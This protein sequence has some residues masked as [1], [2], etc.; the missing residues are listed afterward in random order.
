[1]T[2]RSL[3][4][5]LLLPMVVILG[6]PSDD[7]GASGGSESSSGS[8]GD[9]TTTM[10]SV[11]TVTTTM[12][13]MDSMSMSATTDMTT[14]MTTD[15][16]TAD[17]SGTTDA[18]TTDATTTDAT[19]GTDSGSSGG[20]TTTGGG[21]V[22]YGPCTFSDGQDPT[23]DV[24][25]EECNQLDPNPMGMDGAP[26]PSWCAIPCMSDDDCVAPASGDAVAECSMFFQHC[27]LNC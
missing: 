9:M 19:T 12:T 5:H 16:T 7:G 1:M 17:S 3:K 26:N 27:A 6:C 20:S 25:D 24:M 13:T 23:C 15:M 2:S 21:V 14:T 22:P 18:T 4:L 10:T 8:S 11:T